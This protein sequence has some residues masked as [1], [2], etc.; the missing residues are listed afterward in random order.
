M[1]E[2]DKQKRL[3]WLRAL[4][5]FKYGIR[6][7]AKMGVLESICIQ[8]AEERKRTRPLAA[9]YWHHDN[10]ITLLYTCI[11]DY[12][13]P[14]ELLIGFAKTAEIT[15]L[16]PHRQPTTESVVS[17]VDEICRVHSQALRKKFGVIINYK[18]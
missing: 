12:K 15:F 5:L 14:P 3:E 8:V 4:R 17:V 1:E 11:R 7:R 18:E 13:F 9:P 16:T 6:V 10:S 2:I